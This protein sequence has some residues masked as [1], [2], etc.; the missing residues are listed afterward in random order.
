MAAE[1]RIPVMRSFDGGCNAPNGFERFYATNTLDGHPAFNDGYDLQSRMAESF[2]QEVKQ[3]QPA[4]E[5]RIQMRFP[6]VYAEIDRLKVESELR[7]S[8]FWPLMLLSGLLAWVWSPVALLLAA[9]PPFLLRDGFKRAHEASEK[10][11]S[12]VVAGE[13]A[14]PIL[15]AIAS[16]KNEPCLDFAARYRNHD[17]SAAMN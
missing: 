2:A 3:E 6:E 8:V 13:V 10:T 9:I 17:E 4:V 16:A 7:L 15:D 5:V 1:G 14:S 11:W 12:A